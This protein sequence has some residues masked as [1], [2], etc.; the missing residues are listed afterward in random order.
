MLYS[1]SAIIGFSYPV[2]IASSYC[3]VFCSASLWV[4]FLNFMFMS[5]EWA[6]TARIFSRDYSS[7]L[8]Y[9]SPSKAYA[10]IISSFTADTYSEPT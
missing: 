4:A 3:R 8:T 2:I 10:A 6:L 5:A 1:N 9:L 7:S